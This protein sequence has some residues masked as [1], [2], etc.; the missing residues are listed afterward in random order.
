MP[1]IHAPPKP[2]EKVI[3][4]IDGGYL[5][6]LC[7]ELCGSDDIN[8]ENLLGL[9]VRGFDNHPNNRF[10]ANLIRAYYYDA[11]V[12]QNDPDYNTQRKYFD[13]IPE[14]YPY[15][16][17]LGKLVKSSNKGFKQK[18]VDILMSVDAITK[19]YQNHYDT[20]IFLLGDADFIPL[21]EGVK[22]AGKKTMLVY[23]KANSS[24][25]LINTFDMRIF[26]EE[27][28]LKLFMKRP[29]VS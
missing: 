6:E 5:R 22:D 12:D 7:K 2:F 9:L 26:I 23:Y 16:I 1:I 3:V 11:I 17:R 29:S 21:V 25:A 14:N 20:G 24:K 19:A 8:F 13:A 27:R 15:T 18:G 10:Q 4:F 28:D